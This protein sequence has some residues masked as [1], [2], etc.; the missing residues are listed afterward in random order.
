LLD[1]KKK[2]RDRSL[3][4]KTINVSGLKKIYPNSGT[5]IKNS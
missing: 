2:R 3:I 5:N 4:K 1:E